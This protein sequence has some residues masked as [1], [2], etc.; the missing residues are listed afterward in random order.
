MTSVG[1]AQVVGADGA[2][3]Q[4]QSVVVIDVRVS[5]HLVDL[6]RVALVDVLVHRL[7]LAFFE[8]DQLGLGSRLLDRF[9]RVGELHLLDAVG[10]DDSDLLSFKFVG[11]HGLLP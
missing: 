2:A 9:A 10:R 5:D 4:D 11:H 7:D 8:R 1:L 6:E 3:R